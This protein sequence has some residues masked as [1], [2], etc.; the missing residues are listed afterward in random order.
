MKSGKSGAFTGLLTGNTA[1][2]SRLLVFKGK[3]RK[4]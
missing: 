1:R 3:V 2:T 4:G